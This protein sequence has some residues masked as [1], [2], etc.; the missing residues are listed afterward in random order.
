MSVELPSASGRLEF[1]AGATYQ[2]E[3]L[4][5]YVRLAFRCE[6]R[7][8]EPGGGRPVLALLLA[9]LAVRPASAWGF[10]TSRLEFARVEDLD[11]AVSLGGERVY[12]VHGARPMEDGKALIF[13]DGSGRWTTLEQIVP[14]LRRVVYDENR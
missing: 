9:R 1:L 12:E 13:R 3:W 2:R 4:D 5:P 14:R 11:F 8:V 10:E 7:A 6:F